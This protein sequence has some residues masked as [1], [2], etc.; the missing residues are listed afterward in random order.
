M[1]E[2]NDQ[3]EE[4]SPTITL[5][6]HL[7]AFADPH[8]LSGPEGSTSIW[9]TLPH[10]LYGVTPAGPCESRK[11]KKPV[12]QARHRVR[13]RRQYEAVSTGELEA[14]LNAVPGNSGTYQIP[15]VRPGSKTAAKRSR[16]PTK[17][18]RIL[19]EKH[20]ERVIAHIETRSRCPE[21]DLVK[22]LL[23]HKA[24]L[25]AGEIAAFTFGNCTDVEGR[26]ARKIF[27]GSGISKSKGDREVPM[28][29]R[30][31]E[32]LERLRTSYPHA[33]HVAFSVGRDGKLRH[34]NAAAVT[35]WFSR[36][37]KDVGFIG[38]SSH[39]GRRSFATAIARKLGGHQSSL[40]NLQYW[41]GH[42][43]LSSTQCYLEVSP[44]A[45]ELVYGL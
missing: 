21:S 5:E 11:P 39:T 33:A 17:R 35:N 36:L 25:R 3:P 6:S 27:I 23:S 13:K 32:A 10:G 15:T 7:Q 42:K 22:L 38:C 18:A 45:E 20:L 9:G 34:Q 24:G 29:G 37:Y 31:K 40:A 41:M 14:A 1:C 30:L 4:R 44:A 28:N 16:G 2:S 19:E 26:L 8:W 12:A 43:Q